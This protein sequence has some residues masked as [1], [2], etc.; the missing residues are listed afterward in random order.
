M[1]SEPIGAWG[2]CFSRMPIGRT[3][4]AADRSMACGQSAAV[5]SS[6]RAG[7]S[8]ASAT[9]VRATATHTSAVV[10]RMVLSGFRVRG[11]YALGACEAHLTASARVAQRAAWV[12][13]AG[14]V[15]TR[16]EDTDP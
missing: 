4:V 12:R 5:S 3:Q 2:P 11:H 13:R 8:W 7:R 16:S 10:F 15:Q 6:Q 9:V 14:Y 1:R